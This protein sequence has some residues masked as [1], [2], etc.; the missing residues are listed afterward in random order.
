MSVELLVQQ[1]G[2]HH[3]PILHP[4]P[5]G[6]TTWFNKSHNGI[7]KSINEMM[8]SMLKTGYKTYSKQEINWASGDSTVVRKAFHKKAMEIYINQIYEWKQ[9]WHKG[10]KPKF[11][12]S[13]VWQD[14][15]VHWSKQETEE[16]SAKNSQN[17]L[18]DRGGLGVYVHNLDACSMSSKE[19]QLVAAND[20]NP[21]DYLDV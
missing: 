10:K 16:Q 2:R 9:L 14:L 4:L 5:E 17:R 11:I 1:P 15:E 3:L 21:A 13:K 19:D 8:Y 12:N 6:D 20:G 7:S 18:S